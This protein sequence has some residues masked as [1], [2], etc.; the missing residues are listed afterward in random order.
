MESYDMMFEEIEGVRIHIHVEQLVKW[1]HKMLLLAYGL[2]VLG[3]I[4]SII[5]NG[6]LKGY[7]FLIL[8]VGFFIMS[9]GNSIMYLQNRRRRIAFIHI[10]QSGI[11]TDQ[12]YFLMRDIKTVK[13]QEPKFFKDFLR[14][15]YLIITTADEKRKY[16]LGNISNELSPGIYAGI[17][18]AL[19]KYLSESD[20]KLNIDTVL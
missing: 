3:I 10:N 14:S 17:G 2:F 6:K 18:K 5:Q 13:L 19:Q 9:I 4:I 15:R 20:I 8:T 11:R 1:Y 12:D 16:W 7:F